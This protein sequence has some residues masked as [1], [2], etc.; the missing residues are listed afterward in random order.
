MCTLLQ[1]RATVVY[2]DEKWCYLHSHHPRYLPRAAFEE[3]MVVGLHIKK[4][5]N[6]HHPIKTMF[7]VAV[8]TPDPDHDFDVFFNQKDLQ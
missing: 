5:I 1:N 4:V 6:R 3:K 7:I 8:T 2:I